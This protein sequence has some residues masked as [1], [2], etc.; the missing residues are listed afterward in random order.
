M[1]VRS[2]IGV[3]GAGKTT[4]IAQIEG[5]KSD[6]PMHASTIS[7]KIK[8]HKLPGPVRELLISV[9]R[10]VRGAY[11]RLKDK[12][13]WKDQIMDRSYICGLVYSKYY[14]T[15]K[16]AELLKPLE[17]R[18]DEI[19]LLLPRK[20]DVR[21]KRDLYEDDVGWFNCEYFRTLQDEDY[22]YVDRFGYLFGIVTVWRD[23]Q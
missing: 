23:K 12:F 10:I 7:H 2:Y 21:P 1:T 19:Y 4:L 8:T 5:K 20:N 13:T 16:W 18:P 15:R 14:G 6:K 9:E 3:D 11:L 22:E 17:T